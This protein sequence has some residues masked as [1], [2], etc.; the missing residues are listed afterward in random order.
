MKQRKEQSTNVFTLSDP[1]TPIKDILVGEIITS[2]IKRFYRV[3]RISKREKYHTLENLVDGS[4]V[5]VSWGTT[6]FIVL[7]NLPDERR[8]KYRKIYQE[9]KREQ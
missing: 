2:M 6:D 7:S 8:K 9:L 1:Y 5:K 3:I 4:I